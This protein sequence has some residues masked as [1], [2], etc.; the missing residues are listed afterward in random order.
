MIDAF[1]MIII[2]INKMYKNKTRR[3]FSQSETFF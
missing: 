1:I 2:T 3:I